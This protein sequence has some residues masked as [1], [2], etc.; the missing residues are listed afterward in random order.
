MPAVI[1]IGA[2]NVNT[3]QQNAAVFVGDT[4]ITGC[5]ANQKYNAGQGG[6]FGWL[7]ASLSSLNINNDNFEFADGNINDQDAKPFCGVN[8]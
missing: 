7:N 8:S 1:T 5:D 2:L 4:V 6:F 3:P